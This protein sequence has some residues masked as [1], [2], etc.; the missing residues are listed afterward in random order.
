MSTDKS[1]PTKAQ[2]QRWNKWL[3]KPRGW[4]YAIKVSEISE[5]EAKD[6]LCR[7]MDLIE[8]LDAATTA[9]AWN[10]NAWRN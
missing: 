2:I 5:S 6:E 10:F 7:C 9:I 4:K 3:V 8:K 1:K